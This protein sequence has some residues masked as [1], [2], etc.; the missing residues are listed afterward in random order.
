MEIIFNSCDEMR[1]FLSRIDYLDDG[2]YY[3]N[4]KFIDNSNG[5]IRE[6]INELYICLKKDHLEEYENASEDEKQE[7]FIEHGKSALFAS[8][9]LD[10][11]SFCNFIMDKNPKLEIRCDLVDNPAVV[12]IFSEYPE[13]NRVLIERGFYRLL[14][15]P[16]TV[17]YGIFDEQ[18][19][20]PIHLLTKLVTY[21]ES[22]LTTLK[23]MKYYD[24]D[25][26]VVTPINRE[27]ALLMFLKEL[28]ESQK[29]MGGINDYQLEMLIE[30][31][32]EENLYIEDIRRQYP[33]LLIS[34]LMLK[35]SQKK[36]LNI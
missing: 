26:N 5:E 33:K 32:T 22:K 17:S 25:L 24:V 12:C 6:K 23:I 35:E 29:Y 21:D 30:L 36:K 13:N 9:I 11:P 27:T 14:N 4:A 28:L 20:Y 31:T 3:K 16:V 19:L 7:I 1:N 2:Q 15:I 8:T 10:S 34:K 18:T